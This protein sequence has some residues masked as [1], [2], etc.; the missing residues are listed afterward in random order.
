MEERDA[1][2]ATRLAKEILFSKDV[3]PHQKDRHR[4]DYKNGIDKYVQALSGGPQSSSTNTLIRVPRLSSQSLSHSHWSVTSKNKSNTGS[5]RSS[6]SSLNLSKKSMLTFLVRKEAPHPTINANLSATGDNYHRVDKVSDIN[7]LDNDFDCDDEFDPSVFNMQSRNSHNINANVLASSSS[8]SG[9]I[10]NRVNCKTSSENNGENTKNQKDPCQHV[11]NDDDS[12][13]IWYT[14]KSSRILGETERS[15]QKIHNLREEAI[16]SAHNDPKYLSVSDKNNDKNEIQTDCRNDEE[17]FNILFTKRKK[18][19]AV[20]KK[21]WSCTACTYVNEP[22]QS[23]CEVC[24]TLQDKNISYFPNKKRNN[25]V[26]LQRVS[27]VTID[28]GSL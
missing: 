11:N 2:L 6:S 10:I 3:F 14:S 18:N 7:Y 20:A 8:G 23:S 19:C 12:Q 5:I 16:N 13:H 9:V 26:S 24:G 22:V 15:N 4:K 1:A 28:D 21:S 25:V 27:Y 17:N